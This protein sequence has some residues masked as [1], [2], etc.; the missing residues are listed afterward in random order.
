MI[1]SIDDGGAMSLPVGEV[2]PTL[3]E[4]AA[5]RGG[6]SLYVFGLENTRFHEQ[7]ELMLK[8]GNIG[9]Y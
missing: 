8:R 4:L 5:Q 9:D 6:D 1:Y 7:R 2:A 3:V